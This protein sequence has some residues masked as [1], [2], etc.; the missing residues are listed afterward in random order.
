MWGCKIKTREKKTRDL[1]Q[2]MHIKNEDER[3]LT[4]DKEIIHKQAECFYKLQ[5]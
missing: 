5:R 4:Q 2:I 1:N 3:V